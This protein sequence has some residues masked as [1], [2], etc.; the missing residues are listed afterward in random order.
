MTSGDDI[1]VVIFRTGTQEFAL[2]ISQVERILRY[3][4][5]AAL[6]NA[7]DFLE[8][9]IQYGDGVA[10]VVDLRKRLGLD[11]PVL[12][13]TR[14]MV[15]MVD[16]QRVGMLVDQVREVA[17]IDSRAIAAPP[18]MVRGLAAKYIAGV[19][20]IGERTIVLLHTGR[21]FSTKE[22]LKLEEAVA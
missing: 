11:A 21:L 10:P 14:L 20:T 8:G 3:Q 6:P 15:V 9:V 16:G 18:P 2:E 22:R 12:E 7:P 19:L 1:Q 5:P 17:R 13:D 4:R